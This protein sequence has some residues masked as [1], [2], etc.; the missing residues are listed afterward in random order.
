LAERAPSP[1]H[2]SVVLVVATAEGRA[3]AER[4][5]SVRSSQLSRALASWSDDDRDELGRLLL[6]LVDDLQSTPYLSSDAD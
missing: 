6:R 2:R 4:F 1:G 5:E 3:M